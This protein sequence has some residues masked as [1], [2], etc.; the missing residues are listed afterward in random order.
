MIE[1]ENGFHDPRLLV[2]CVMADVR[3]YMP[4]AVRAKSRIPPEPAPGNL[5][6]EL[7]E[8]AGHILIY[9]RGRGSGAFSCLALIE[10]DVP[11]LVESRQ[12]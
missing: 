10:L 7:E 9:A 8:L 12:D 6:V 1:S 4:L 5:K 3:Q 2:G 11:T